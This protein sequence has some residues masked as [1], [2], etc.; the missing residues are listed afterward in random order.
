MGSPL[1]LASSEASTR[2]IALAAAIGAALAGAGLRLGGLLP[3]PEGPMD[4]VVVSCRVEGAADGPACAAAQRFREARLRAFGG[5]RLRTR[6]PGPDRL[7][8]AM[9]GSMKPEDR[10]WLLDLVQ[11]T[12]M[13]VSFHLVAPE[14]DQAPARIEEVR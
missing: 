7:D 10:R 9:P 14:E 2:R 4:P 8:I 6:V 3:Q 5:A 12:G 1:Y 11:G 13:T